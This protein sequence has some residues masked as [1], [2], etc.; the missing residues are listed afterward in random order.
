MDTL[1]CLCVYLIMDYFDILAGSNLA[2]AEHYRSTATLSLLRAGPTWVP[3]LAVQDVS[4]RHYS[5]SCFA[6]LGY[7]HPHA[8][9]G[10][11]LLKHDSITQKELYFP[12]LIELMDNQ[13]I[14]A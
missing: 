7:G 13:W 14:I 3:P 2:T 5:W 12:Q 6:S 8:R 1:V 9:D 10:Y 4:Y 11:R